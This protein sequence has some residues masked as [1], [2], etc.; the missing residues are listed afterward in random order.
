[1]ALRI[2]GPMGQMSAA[3]YPAVMADDEMIPEIPAAEPVVDEAIPEMAASEPGSVAEWIQEALDISG[4]YPDWPPDLQYALESALALLIG[5][6]AVGATEGP[7]GPVE[8]EPEVPVTPEAPV[9]EED[10]EEL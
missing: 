3:S 8:T 4:R 5:P 9:P 1:M 2:G 10:E 6:A 7:P